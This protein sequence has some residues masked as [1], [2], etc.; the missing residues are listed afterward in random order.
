MSGLARQAERAGV[1]I[2][3]RRAKTRP[4]GHTNADE[5]RTHNLPF[6]SLGISSG[7]AIS[8]F[9]F[10]L[11]ADAEYPANNTLWCCCRKDD[12]CRE[13]LCSRGRRRSF[14]CSER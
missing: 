9:L 4:E 7:N 2:E 3:A 14:G 5:L 13:N 1:R 12:P 10:R 6:S 8:T 11:A